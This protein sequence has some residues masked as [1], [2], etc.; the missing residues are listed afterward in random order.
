MLVEA[1]DAGWL[2]L[3][4]VNRAELVGAV[5]EALKVLEDAGV[6]VSSTFDAPSHRG[7]PADGFR[8]A[9][10][11][12]RLVVCSA[13]DAQKRTVIATLADCGGDLPGDLVVAADGFV[14]ASSVR[15]REE[16]S[17]DILDADVQPLLNFLDFL[18]QNDRAALVQTSSGHAAIL[19]Q[20]IDARRAVL[21]LTLA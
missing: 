14:R 15:R 12:H 16:F 18:L 1:Y 21:T 2:R 5:S 7:R 11:E 20:R 4:A 10:R 3:L 19:P 6:D 8:N 13:R 9:P 17:L